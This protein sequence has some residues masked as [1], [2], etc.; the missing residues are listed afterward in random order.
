MASND[1]GEHA[2]LKQFLNVYWLRPENALWRALNCYAIRD[3]EF[4]EPSLDL[5]CG[6]GIFSFLRAG[7]KFDTDF[8]IFQ[9]TDYLDSF[10]ENEDIYNSVP[11]GYSPTV[12]KEPEYQVTVG[13]DWKEALLEKA[14][15]LDMYRELKQHDN[16]NPL[17]FED[18]RFKTIFSNS[19]YWIENIDLHL[20]E[21][22]RVLH[23]DGKAILVLKTPA[24]HQFLETLQA[25]YG[26][27]LGD[28]LID[29]LDRGRRNNKQHLHDREGWTNKLQEAG[30]DVVD[31]RTSVTSLH[32]GLWDIGLRPV[33]PH[34]IKMAYS[35]EQERRTEIKEDWL[36]T[37]WDLL[38]PIC[39]TSVG[40]DQHGD[41]PEL[42]YILE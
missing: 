37:W 29:I 4:D 41:P 13:T 11:D 19:A 32:A 2:S 30:F 21:I 34:L 10:F 20:S 1:N 22:N 40:L 18:D 33:S 14:D 7:G 17:P 28:E 38:K 16:N 12:T 5:S 24:V 25:D 27:L 42:I 23:P 36:D 15:R 3:V 6:D 35:L 9:G 26:E 39:D 8:D 31:C